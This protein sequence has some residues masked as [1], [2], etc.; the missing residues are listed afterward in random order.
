VSETV[1]SDSNAVRRVGDVEID[2]DAGT[3]Y[4]AGQRIQLPDLSFRLLAALVR[5]APAAVE[6]DDLIREVWGSV[7]VSDETLA[8]RVSLLR[9]ALGEDTREGSMIAVVR[10]RGYRL[11][12]TVEIASREQR[13]V[14]IRVGAIAALVLCA[15]ALLLGWLTLPQHSAGSAEKIDSLAVLPFT[16]L[17]PGRDHGYFADGMQEELLARLAQIDGMAVAS[18]TSVTGDHLTSMSLPE[19]AERLNVAAVIEGS[20]RIDESKVRITVQLIEAATDTHLWAET[21][22]RGLSVEGIFAIQTEVAE[23]VA[24]LIPTAGPVQPAALPTDNLDAYRAYLLGRFHTFRQTEAD[25]QLGIEYLQTA[26]DLDSE[27]ASAYASIGWAYS[28]LGT[29]YGRQAPGAVFPKAREAA[30]RALALNADLA[31]SRSLYADILT[32]Y[33]WDFSAAEREYRK[34]MAL[35]HLNVLGYAILLSI[36]N[37]GAEAVELVEQ[38]IAEGPVEDY[39][40]VNAAWRYLNARQFDKAIDAGLRAGRHPDA[41]SALG[42]AYWRSGELPKAIGIYEEDLRTHPKNPQQLS[43]LASAYFVADRNAE[44]ATLLGELEAQAELAYVSPVLLAN[45][46][47]AAGDADAGFTALEAGIVARAREVLFIGFNPVYEPWRE[48]PRYLQLIAKIGLEP[49]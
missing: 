41:P 24:A 11:N 13:R 15:G 37:R 39:V 26:I 3:V 10:S 19:I 27:F 47:F 25:L 20:V 44:G 40:Y 34:A 42:T 14:R 4:R 17:S 46:H 36:L 7:V 21:F 31:D 16:D 6:K 30:L 2:L 32:W 43:N 29:S 33:D 18:R 45:V 38:R 8:Q 35:D 22:E 49:R 12:G 1:Q 48:D 9:K 5:R 23:K 28:F